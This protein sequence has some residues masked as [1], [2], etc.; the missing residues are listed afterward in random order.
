MKPPAPFIPDASL[1]L[2]DAILNLK[3]ESGTSVRGFRYVL[4]DEDKT[5]ASVFIAV[6]D[7]SHQIGELLGAYVDAVA[8]AS[9]GAAVAAHSP[10]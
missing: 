2:K 10:T 9:N 5:I 4:D 8:T 7:E 6:G 3:P 1:S